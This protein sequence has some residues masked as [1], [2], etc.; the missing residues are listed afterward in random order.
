MVAERP[1]STFRFRFGICPPP[2]ALMDSS[3]LKVAG[4]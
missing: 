2:E 1:P 4:E 3:Q